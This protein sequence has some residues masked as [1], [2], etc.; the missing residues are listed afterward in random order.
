MRTVSLW[1]ISLLM[2]GLDWSHAA[3]IGVGQPGAP[4]TAPSRTDRRTPP[5][6]PLDKQFKRPPRSEDAWE[7]LPKDI[8]EKMRLVGFESQIIGRRISYLVYLPDGYDL[9][10]KVRYP[11]IY[12][13]PPLRGDCREVGILAQR[14]DTM[15]R[16]K[17]CLPIIMVGVQGIYGSM[18]TDTRDGARPIESVI[19]NEVVQ[20]VDATFRT[21]AKREGRALEGLF[22]GGY[23][24][25]LLGFKYPDTFGVV[26]M[27]APPIAPLNWF[28]QE[29]PDIA[30]D[31]WSN[32]QSYFDDND[33]FLLV[34]RNAERIRGRTKIRMFVGADDPYRIFTDDFHAKLDAL[35]IEHQY[36]VVPGVGQNGPALLKALK[37]DIYLFWAKVFPVDDMF[38]QDLPASL[39][40]TQS[41][42]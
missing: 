31:V 2:I 13:L 26:S 30:S 25:A 29:S 19:V 18:Y 15:I 27:F 17:Q 20:K 16:R 40:T 22:M 5:P 10:P 38:K 23:G 39:P 36:Q 14:L 7:I 4:S 35:G 1:L 37:G 9:N 28:Q 21:L 24:A 3:P 33:P 6:P 12:V 34:E 32:N 42:P 41:E 11:V 8:P